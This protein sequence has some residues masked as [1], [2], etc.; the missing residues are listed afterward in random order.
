MIL[1]VRWSDIV[2]ELPISEIE[3]QTADIL[4]HITEGVCRA[5]KVFLQSFVNISPTFLSSV[6]IAKVKA[7]STDIHTNHMLH[8]STTPYSVIR[9]FDTVLLKAETKL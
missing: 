2:R 9:I 7:I 6:L 1:S 4:G 8:H 3:K 5:L